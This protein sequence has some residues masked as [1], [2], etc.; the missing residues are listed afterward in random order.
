MLTAS[1]LAAQTERET[2]P[3][4]AGLM[5]LA[6]I[7]GA[8]D[9]L[10][11][12]C[13]NRDTPGWRDQMQSLLEAEAEEPNRRRRFVERFNQG[14]RGFASVYRNCTPSARLAME[15]YVAEGQ[16]LIS[17]VTGRYGR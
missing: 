8:L 4:E 16:K 2:P 11:P 3:Y 5:R 9:V 6:E 1:P 10:R 12:L 14:Y 17:D 13:G 15:Q 7:L